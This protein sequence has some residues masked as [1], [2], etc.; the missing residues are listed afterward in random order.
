MHEISDGDD[1]LL[2]SDA[3]DR[4]ELVPLELVSQAEQYSARD[5]RNLPFLIDARERYLA[6]NVS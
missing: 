1:S 5:G 2:G 3:L 6:E 4:A